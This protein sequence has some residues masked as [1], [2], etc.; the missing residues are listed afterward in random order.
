MSSGAIQDC[1]DMEE[2]CHVSRHSGCLKLTSAKAEKISGS[3]TEKAESFTSILLMESCGCCP[4]VSISCCF[5]F[6]SNKTNVGWSPLYKDVVK[7]KGK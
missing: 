5:S 1:N 7:E 4:S 2:F 6:S 3:S